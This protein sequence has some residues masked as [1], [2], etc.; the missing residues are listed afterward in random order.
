MEQND[1]VI[2]IN[3]AINDFDGSTPKLHEIICNLNYY[4]L[5]GAYYFDLDAIVNNSKQE[6]AEKNTNY[7]L[8]GDYILSKYSAFVSRRINNLSNIFEKNSDILEKGVF[9]LRIPDIIVNEVE[10]KKF[11]GGDKAE[12]CK[13][14]VKLL[15]INI[16]ISEL[17]ENLSCNEEILN[18]LELFLGIV[19][20][21]YSGEKSFNIITNTT[22]SSESQQ[23]IQKDDVQQRKDENKKIANIIEDKIK[24]LQWKIRLREF[25]SKNKNF[26]YSECQDFFKEQDSCFQEQIQKSQAHY[27]LG[28]VPYCSKPLTRI[29]DSNNK[30]KLKRVSGSESI[31]FEEVLK[32]SRHLRKRLDE[33]TLP[34]ESVIEELKQVLLI[35]K[36]E[37]KLIQSDEEKKFDVFTIKSAYNLIFNTYIRILL[38]QEFSNNF[39]NC[40]SDLKSNKLNDILFIR[41]IVNQIKDLHDDLK[42]DDYYPFQYILRFFQDFI[43]KIREDVLAAFGIEKDTIDEKNEKDYTRKAEEKLE[44]V[45]T[46]YDQAIKNFKEK[47]KWSKE[48]KLNP[49]YLGRESSIIRYGDKTLFLDS[50]YILPDNF[51]K[52]EEIW[53]AEEQYKKVTIRSTKNRVQFEIHR[54]VTENSVDKKKDEFEKKVKE[55]EFK[56]VQ[57]VA[58]F[59]SIATFVLGNI[60]IFE[61]KTLDGGLSIMFAFAACLLMFNAFFKW[62]IRDSILAN[63][64]A[65]RNNKNE[66]KN[67][68]WNYFTQYKFSVPDGILLTFIIGFAGLSIFFNSQDE[69]SFRD[70]KFMQEYRPLIMKENQKQRDELLKDIY[71]DST[72]KDRISEI[73][74][75]Q[76]RKMIKKDSLLRG[77]IKNIK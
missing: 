41:N 1:K 14:A 33:D 46:L 16:A 61:N 58:L 28:K 57:I 43:A 73:I 55:N 47:F 51:D 42:I 32:W 25:I 36:E 45:G 10:N 35:F 27:L 62:L 72:E 38:K 75:A 60:R 49:I 65:T 40:L 19:R 5:S 68:I 59:V 54:V 67:A 30:Y 12:T 18:R 52:V 50:S 37:L 9:D 29:D 48:R 34:Y 69:S 64:E 39:A 53:Y 15:F 6:K 4:I 7:I 17:E 2:A 63:M 3:R 23:G 26:T 44:L 77:D 21:L 66:S 8:L 70:G 13:I 71:I 20:T 74:D 22:L 31:D 11:Y 24:Y 76:I 56:M